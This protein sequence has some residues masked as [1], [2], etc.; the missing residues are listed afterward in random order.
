[1]IHPNR[2]R[3][4]RASGAAPAAPPGGAQVV[5]GWGCG[6]DGPVSPVSTVILLGCALAL[7]LVVIPVHADEATLSG[8]FVPVSV[9]SGQRVLL[10]EVLLDDS[11]G[12]LW[13]RFRFVAPEISRQSDAAYDAAAVGGGRMDYERSAADMEHLCGSVVLDY[14]RE[15]ALSPSMVVISFS[16]RPVEFGFQDAEATQFFEAY[17]LE[18]D[19]CIW[20][21]F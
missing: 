15:H 9:P 4:A 1:M 2:Y 14:L 21:A 18:K 10:S 8:A 13:A 5:G 7:S 19:R 20:E 11:P 3:I 6:L 16:D 12:A 17:R